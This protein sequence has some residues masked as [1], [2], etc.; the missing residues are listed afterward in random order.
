MY[1]MHHTMVFLVYNTHPGDSNE[2]LSIKS[3]HNMP[4]NMVSCALYTTEYGKSNPTER[5]YRMC[6]SNTKS[7]TSLS[8]T[9]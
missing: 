4:L 5:K 3:G 9:L 1:N 7:I 2:F 6:Y 8:K